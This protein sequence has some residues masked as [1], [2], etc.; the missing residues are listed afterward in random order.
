M[1]ITKRGVV[2]VVL[3]IIAM[4]V[5]LWISLM[6]LTRGEI[7]SEK[8]ADYAALERSE[9][10]QKGWVPA[11]MPKVAKDIYEEHDL[12]TNSVYGE[13]SAPSFAQELAGMRKLTDAEKIR[14]IDVMPWGS[15]RRRIDKQP[16]F[17]W[18]GRTE[19]M[20]VHLVVGEGDRIIY[21]GRADRSC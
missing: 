12:D 3:G 18:C 4:A 11:F 1:V 17:I 16:V 2:Y 21:W 19:K 13:F 9:S 5:V 14:L 10:W 7:R 15:L 20:M 6:L 8:F